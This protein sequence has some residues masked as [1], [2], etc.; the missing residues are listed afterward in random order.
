MKTFRPKTAH[1]VLKVIIE[2]ETVLSVDGI[3]MILNGI[4][5]EDGSGHN[6]IV[7]INVA[8]TEFYIF[9]REGTPFT[10]AT[11]IALDLLAKKK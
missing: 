3:E 10:P 11:R 5:R 9:W 1:D 2:G 6:W 8:Q 4:S 7:E